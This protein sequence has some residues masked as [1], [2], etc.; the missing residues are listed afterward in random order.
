M[1]KILITGGC[2]YIG[3]HTA[4]E[5]LSNPEIEVISVDNLINSSAQTADRVGQIA[6][7][8]MKNY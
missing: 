3:S 7:R 6:G 4:I 2:G 8:N 5:L 1:T